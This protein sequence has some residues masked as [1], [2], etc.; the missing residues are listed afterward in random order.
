MLMFTRRVGWGA[1]VCTFCAEFVQL[2]LEL[3]PVTVY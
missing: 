1:N 2:D 3:L